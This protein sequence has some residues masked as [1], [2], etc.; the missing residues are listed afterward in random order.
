MFMSVLCGMYQLVFVLHCRH[1]PEVALY[2]PDS[3]SLMQKLAR[4]VCVCVCV[5]TSCD[6]FSTISFCTPVG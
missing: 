1:C 2:V 3:S 5:C 4:C 6:V